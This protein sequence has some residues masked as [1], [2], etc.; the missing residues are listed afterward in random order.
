MIDA[1]GEKMGFTRKDE[2]LNENDFSTWFQFL[3]QG[4]QID[5]RRV[6]K[7]L[8]TGELPYHNTAGFISTED[9]LKRYL[10]ENRRG[11]LTLKKINPEMSTIWLQAEQTREKIRSNWSRIIEQG[12][13]FD[14]FIKETP[15]L[16]AFLDLLPAGKKSLYLDFLRK[17][18]EEKIPW[19]EI[20]SRKPKEI[21]AIESEL[22]QIRN[23]SIYKEVKVEIPPK[24]KK[25]PE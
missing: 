9:F 5:M 13:D 22:E 2:Q 15:E 7:M 6:Q 23:D 3:N 24:D 14:G 10:P 16:M 12:L 21:K 19:K 25:I 4:G 18:S 17:M 1:Y 11:E 20:S 8:E